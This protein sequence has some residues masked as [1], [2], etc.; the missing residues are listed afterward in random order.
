[1]ITVEQRRKSAEAI[2]K[3][4]VVEEKNADIW[5]NS[6]NRELGNRTPNQVW[7]EDH[8]QVYDYVVSYFWRTT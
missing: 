3:V 5:W 1:M 8:R 6:P 2:V 4:L 7:E